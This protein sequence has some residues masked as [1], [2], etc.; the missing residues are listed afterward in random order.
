M[1]RM[2]AMT[3]KMDAQYKEFQSRSKQPNP[4]HDE[5]DIPMSREEEAKFMQTLCRTCFYD[6]YHDRDSNCDNWRSSG[7]NNYNRENYQSHSDD[8]PDLQKQL[9]DFIKAQHS[10][11]SFVKDTFM[12][13][14]NK[15]KTTTKNH[16]ASIQNLEA[17]FDRFTDKQSGRPFGSLPSKCRVLQYTK[18]IK[19]QEDSLDTMS[20]QLVELKN[21]VQI[22]QTIISKLK[23]CLL[24]KDSENEHLK[25]KIVDF[26]TVQNLRVQ[27]KELQNENEHLKSKVIDCTMYQNLQVQVEELKSVNESLNLTVEEL[28]KARALAEA[29]LRERDEMINAQCKKIRLLEEQSEIFHEVP[30]EFDS[31]IVH[32]THDNSKKDVILSLQTQLKETAELVVFENK[33]SNLEK[34]LAQRVKD[35]DDV[36][37]ELSKRTNK[38]ETYFANLEK[39]NALLKS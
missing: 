20:D 4:D 3:I 16:Q 2:D 14:K 24:N 21:T 7:R 34:D 1:A 23:E 37:T 13:L 25:L 5:I 22:K 29:T 9:S 17:K 35:F 11:N 27:V 30:S 31:E 6:D 15:L 10:T 32:D 18:K 36:K 38:F 8:K 33:I 19:E 28:S 26:T 12:D 39:E